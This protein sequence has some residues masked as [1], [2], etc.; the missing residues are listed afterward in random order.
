MKYNDIFYTQLYYYVATY[1]FFVATNNVTFTLH[2][3]MQVYLVQQCLFLP[4]L[5]I[6]SVCDVYWSY[7]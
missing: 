5:C 3:G 4:L 1:V 2:V 7:E 6:F